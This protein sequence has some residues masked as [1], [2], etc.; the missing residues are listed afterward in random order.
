M[1][2]TLRLAVL[3][4]GGGT[5]LQNLIDRCA[6]GRL[7]A[8][9]AVVVVDRADALALERARRAGIPNAIV[10][11]KGKS[12]RQLGAETF[13]ICRAHHVD[14][15][16]MGGYLRLVEIPDDFAGRVLN[17]HPSLIPAFC[18]KGFHGRRVHEA[19]LA[20]GCKIS[21]CTIHL[22]D[23]QYDHGP[24]LSQRAVAV[25]PDDTPD[26]LAARV[27]AAEC[28]AL[29]EAIQQWADKSKTGAPTTPDA[30]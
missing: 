23:N 8:R 13:A 11:G 28:E 12:S 10:L 16:V 25:A 17:V 14:L 9:I 26:S 7:S 20:R 21:G 2:E 24:I 18:G 4:S 22:V 27:F 3:A 19:V 1:K 29:P 30:Q 15:V 6:D 5:T